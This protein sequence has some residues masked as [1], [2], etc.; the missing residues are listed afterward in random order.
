MPQILKPGQFTLSVDRGAPIITLPDVMV[1]ST[2]GW[3]F[4]NRAM[5]LVAD[6]PGDEGFLM[7]RMT[8]AGEDVAPEH[9]DD[10]VA[11]TGSV[12]LVVQGAHIVAP[13]IG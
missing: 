5:V 2:D 1:S 9:W 8:G 3:S 4:L 11:S 12:R 7:A 6:G 10:A 13:V